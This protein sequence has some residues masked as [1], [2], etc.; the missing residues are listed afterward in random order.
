MASPLDKTPFL[1]RNK[2]D[3]GNIRDIRF[4]FKRL[5]RGIQI[6][7]LHKGALEAEPLHLLFVL[8]HKPGSESLSAG[9]SRHFSPADQ[10]GAQEGGL[11]EVV[12]AGAVVAHDRDGDYVFLP[13]AKCG[14]RQFVHPV[15]PVGAPGRTEGCKHA[16]HLHHIGAGAG[17]GQH[18]R[19]PAFR[20]RPELQPAV[21]NGPASRLPDGD[22]FLKR[23]IFHK[24]F[25]F[26][27]GLDLLLLKH[28][29]LQKAR[30]FVVFLTFFRS[31]HHHS[32]LS[33][34]AGSGR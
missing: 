3:R 32:G 6:V 26:S 30:G 20:F 25:S 14:Q 21:H 9:K 17:Q 8:R 4:R 10:L 15:K 13:I 31:A 5:I 24:N 27:T 12:K 23:I 18:H 2:H 16:V 22:R 29:P 19:L 1:R 28:N 34:A 7:N 33:H 11:A